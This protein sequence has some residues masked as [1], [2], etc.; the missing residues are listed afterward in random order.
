MDEPLRSFAKAYVRDNQQSRPTEG[1]SKRIDIFRLLELAYLEQGLAANI[2]ELNS[3]LLNR[4]IQMAA[5]R[6]DE[7][8]LSHY[9]SEYETLIVFLNQNGMLVT[10]F[11]W[12]VQ[13]RRREKGTRK[14]IQVGEE[15]DRRRE[16]NLPS[17]EAIAGLGIIF[18]NEQDSDGVIITAATG[19]LLFCTNGRIGEVVT[20]PKNAEFHNQ[21]SDDA[22]AYGLRWR[23]LKGA[24]AMVKWIM[25]DMVPTAQAAITKIRVLTEE[26]RTVAKWYEKHPD[27]MYLPKHLEHYRNKGRLTLA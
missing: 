25:P 20:L 26:A 22:M 15:A 5:E 14:A 13:V 4:A 6:F 1:V 19:A 8:S 21:G 16:D 3:T 23:P 7:C 10:P 2:W 17:P 9:S 27:K 24:D 11:T 12:R 18:Q